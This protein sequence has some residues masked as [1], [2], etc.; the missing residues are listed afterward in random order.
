MIILEK[1]EHY[2]GLCEKLATTQTTGII[3]DEKDL[4]R[5]RTFFGK[6]IKILPAI[7]PFKD[8]FMEQ[9]Q[10]DMLKI[11]FGAGIFQIIVGLF[12]VEEPNAW[13]EGVSIIVACLFI[14]LLMAFCL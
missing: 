1:V 9:V 6:N 13:F 2:I 4:L 8:I 7:K 10:D 11:L 5:R 12:N 14:S 3:G